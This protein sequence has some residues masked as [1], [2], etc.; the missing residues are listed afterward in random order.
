MSAGQWRRVQAYLRLSLSP[1]QVAGR[2][3]GE[4][5]FRIS[6][7]TIYQRV[8]RDKRGGGDLASHLRCHKGRRKRYA[9]G[10]DRRGVSK[11]RGLH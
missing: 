11:D 10:Q 8:Y 1:Q 5:A 2:L 3:R 9:S 7:E 4:G 6:H